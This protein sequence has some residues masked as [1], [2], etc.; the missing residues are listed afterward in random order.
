ME[1]NKTLYVGHVETLDD[2]HR[3]INGIIDAATKE[4]AAVGAAYFIAA[5]DRD[6]R[7]PDGGKI[8]VSSEVTGQDMQNVIKHAFTHNKDLTSLG[9]WIGGEIMRRNKDANIKIKKRGKKN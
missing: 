3:R 6:G 9:L 5:I 7:D 4:L 1:K 8:F 2:K